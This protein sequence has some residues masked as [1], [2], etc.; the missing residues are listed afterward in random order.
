M[1]IG[2]TH[3][4]TSDS[5]IRMHR[6]VKVASCILRNS[7]LNKNFVSRKRGALRFDCFQLGSPSAWNTA[8]CLNFKRRNVRSPAAYPTMNMA[9]KIANPVSGVRVVI[10]CSDPIYHSVCFWPIADSH[11]WLNQ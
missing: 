7:N 8:P 2:T 4:P 9:T 5:N 3:R 11:A 6:V 10:A 1:E